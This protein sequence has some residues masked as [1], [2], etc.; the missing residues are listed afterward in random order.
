MAQAEEWAR[1]EAASPA[2][3]LNRELSWLEFNARVLALA[4][5]PARP[6]LERVRFLAIFSTNLDEFFEV[7]V[8]GLQEQAQAGLA[9][10]TP[11]GLPPK[12]LLARIRARVEELQEEQAGILRG[13]LNELELAGV[14]LRRPDDLEPAQRE[15]LHSYFEERVFP[16]LTPVAIE[17]ETPLPHFSHRSLNL[18]VRLRDPL[19]R[20]THVARIKV[21]P[22]LPRLV[23]LPG[24][25]LVPLEQV[26]AHHLRSLFPGMEVLSHHLFRITRDADLDVVDDD[27]EDLLAAVQTELSLRRA[28]VVRLELERQAPAEL[29]ELLVKGHELRPEDVYFAS[30]LLGMG[31]L[32]EL[33]QLDRPDLKD[34]PWKP[35]TQPEL[36]SR[37][38]RPADLFSLLRR[39]DVL[40]HH[41]YD[42]FTT[43][44]EAFVE[45]AARDPQVLAIKQTLYRT[46]GP[47]SPIARALVRAAEEG[48]QVVVIVELKARGDE[49]ANIAWSQ[50][51]EEAGAEVVFGLVNLKTH[52]K[53]TLVVRQEEGRVRRYVHIGTGN[54]NP[55]TAEAYEDIGLLSADPDLGADVSEL[56]NFLTGYSR[57]RRYRRLLVAPAGLRA[58]ILRLI[59]RE[60]RAGGRIAIKVNN[61]VDPQIIEALYAAARAGAE[62]ELVVRGICCLRPGVPGLS[63][64][65]RVRSILGRYLEHSRIYRF[66]QGARAEHYLG[67]ADL[68]PRN[69]DRRVEAVV[70]VADRGL[71]ARLDQILELN[72]DDDS[73]AWELGAEGSWRR[74]PGGGRVDAQRDL[75]AQARARGRGD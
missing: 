16:V 23:P 62:V 48:K 53:I 26:I 11:D 58:G 28:R 71:K 29:L 51:L 73:L 46:S 3:F 39:Q 12:E 13:L 41:P 7:R 9:P 25:D 27:V 45:Q 36:R 61:L 63:E 75:M 8:A 40:L 4:A 32:G 6:L 69:L 34:E 68:M 64:R 49:Q 30:G 10:A 55:R 2:R 74:L 5:G 70:P 33:Y 1:P 67:S 52:A 18:A 57:Q 47:A 60:S 17:P 21:P 22:L 54:Y 14:R 43:S 38:G 19:R 50:A 20:E 24:G 15:R 66:G 31:A 37:R 65:V 35:S 56:F 72:L 59:K 44:V 42:S